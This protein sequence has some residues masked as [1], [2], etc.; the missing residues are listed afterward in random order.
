MK[1]EA[2]LNK[3]TKVKLEEYARTQGVE[4]DR[5][6]TKSGMIA[7]FFEKLETSNDSTVEEKPAIVIKSP[8]EVA[9]EEKVA[10]VKAEGDQQFNE[11]KA[12]IDSVKSEDVGNPT[13]WMLGALGKYITGHRV[14]CNK[15]PETGIVTIE[16]EGPSIN[17]KFELK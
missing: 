14:K 4:L 7:E 16:S 13:M 8:D 6:K 17:G 3:L 11:F 5:R 2:E 12:F 9:E 1:T 10:A 15:D